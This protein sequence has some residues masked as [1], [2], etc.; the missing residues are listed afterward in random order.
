MENRS[1]SADWTA[2][3]CSA[4]GGESR[5]IVSEINVEWNYGLFV[6]SGYR[7]F[8]WSRAIPLLS[9]AAG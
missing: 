4:A 6:S 7:L 9:G 2:V 8:D 1:S 3:H 5:W